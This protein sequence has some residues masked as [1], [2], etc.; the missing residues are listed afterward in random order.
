[1]WSSASVRGPSLVESEPA[2]QRHLTELCLRATYF[3][4]E[5]QFFEQ[6]DGAAMGS[7]L[8]PIV[9]N[10]YMESF[11]RKAL[12]SAKLTPT[13]WR[14]CVDDMFVLWPHGA[15][16]L[17]EFHAHLTNQHPQIQFTKEV[18]EDDKINFLDVLVK[19]ENDRFS[20]MVYRKPTQ[21]GR[22][23][24]FASHHHPQVKSGTIRCLSERARKICLDEDTKE[25]LNHIRNTFLKNGYPKHVIARN[26]QS[27]QGQPRT[28]S[29]A[30][31]DDGS[32]KR[33]NLFLPYVQGLSER[34]QIA[35]RKLNIKTVFK[36]SGTLRSTLTRVKTKTPE[37]KKRRV[38]YEVPCQ[39]C[40]ASYVGET[41]RTLQKR[42]RNISMQLGQMTGRMALEYMHGTWNTD[43]T[44]M[45]QKSWRRN[46]VTGR[47]AS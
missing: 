17:E 34:I 25:E 2:V 11:E 7:P 8:S 26:L 23:T 4:F 46:H 24:H 33:P 38:V 3:M 31:E 6:V 13:V 15:N 1:M 35:C 12:S 16:Q 43:L 37:L 36:S 44:G 41:G 9:A 39:D 5:D 18:E 47:D 30:D 28:T 27:K 45:Q 29:N 42:S 21:T 32:T 20:T 10:L 19:K 14:R 40:E 22:Y